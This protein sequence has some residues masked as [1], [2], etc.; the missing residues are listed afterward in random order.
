MPGL[1]LLDSPNSITGYTSQGRTLN[2]DG[3]QGVANPWLESSRLV[4]DTINAA[5]HCIPCRRR[6]PLQPFSGGPAG[7]GGQELRVNE[8]PDQ[9]T[10]KA[11]WSA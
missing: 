10:R 7:K 4:N 11:G 6:A 1:R 3:T 9:A 8:E 2:L 5:A